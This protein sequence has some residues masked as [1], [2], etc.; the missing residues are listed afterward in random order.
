MADL[1]KL[2]VAAELQVK[3]KEIFRHATKPKG[4]LSDSEDIREREAQANDIAEQAESERQLQ[5]QIEEVQ[6]KNEAY[7]AEN[8]GLRGC[9]NQNKALKAE[10]KMKNKI[11]LDLKANDKESLKQAKIQWANVKSNLPENDE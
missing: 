6:R 8:A 9:N 11:F 2:L 4:F 10:L 7:L 5:Q 3:R 1:A